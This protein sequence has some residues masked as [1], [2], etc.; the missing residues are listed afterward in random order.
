MSFFFFQAEDGIRDVAVTG[1]QTCALP[2]SFPF[3]RTTDVEM[4]PVPLTVRVKVAPPAVAPVGEIEVM[5]GTGFDGIGTGVGAGVG[6]P[7][8]A[9]RNMARESSGRRSLT[10]SVN[11][12]SMSP[13]SCTSADGNRANA[14]TILE[15]LRTV[16]ERNLISCRNAS[17]RA[18]ARS[19][20]HT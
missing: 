7:P 1:V 3:Q 12:F 9:V 13:P 2:I 8:Q 6:A 5:A 17:G 14:P 10:F 19:E 4:K 15:F 16:K 20:E 11:R 18:I